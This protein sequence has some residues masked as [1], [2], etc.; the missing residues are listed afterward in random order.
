[1]T[2]RLEYSLKLVVPF[3][4]TFILVYLVCIFGAQHDGE[5]L[6]PLARSRIVSIL[7]RSLELGLFASFAVWVLVL[8]P[9]SKRAAFIAL[10]LALGFFTYFMLTS[11]STWEQRMYNVQLYT[12]ILVGLVCVS[13]I[14]RFLRQSSMS[15]NAEPMENSIPRESVEESPHD[16]PPHKRGG[17]DPC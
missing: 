3:V 5:R 9:N 13:L 12:A 8:C 6:H 11:I 2:T 15:K 17:N 4:V 14:F 7:L 1:M 16:V 10:L